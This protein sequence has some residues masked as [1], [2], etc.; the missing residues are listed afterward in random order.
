[1]PMIDGKYEHSISQGMRKRTESMKQKASTDSQQV[2][3]E[4]GDTSGGAVKA[5]LQGAHGE[6][7]KQAKSSA[8]V[9]VHEGGAHHLHVHDHES[10]AHHKSEHSS[11]K[12]AMGAA[13]E[14]LAKMGGGD[15]SETEG[16]G[17]L[18]EMAG[19]EPMSGGGA[20]EEMGLES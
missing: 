3:G 1:M 14:N 13:H 19:N 8:H 7:A 16:S 5:H 18:E 20:M 10:G 9:Y 12:E 4:P 17:G 15:S 6:D 11:L 2:A